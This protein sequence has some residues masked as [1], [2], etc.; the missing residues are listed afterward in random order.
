M[1][2][3]LVSSTISSSYLRSVLR[4]PSVLHHLHCGRVVVVLVFFFFQA[5]DGIRDIGVTGVQ[6]CAL[7]I[8]SRGTKIISGGNPD[9]SNC[10]YQ[11]EWGRFVDALGRKYDGDSNVAFIDISGYGAYNE[12]PYV[13]SQTDLKETSLDYMARKRLVDMFMG[14]SSNAQ[15]CRDSNGNIRTVSYS[16]RGIQKTQLIMPYAGIVQST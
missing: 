5:E 13:N 1:L 11:E 14:G 8:L 3:I 4:I 7:P 15:K 9:F 16:Y 12:W 6:T 2:C 10:T